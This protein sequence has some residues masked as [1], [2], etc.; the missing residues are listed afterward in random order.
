MS[1]WEGKYWVRWND[2]VRE[3]GLEPNSMQ[4]AFDKAVLI[5]KFISLMRDLGHFPVDA[6]IRMKSRSDPS[7]PSSNTYDSRLRSVTK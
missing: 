3:A 4:P 5:E 6:E 7:F 2:A 1:V